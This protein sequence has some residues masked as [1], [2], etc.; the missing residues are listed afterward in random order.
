MLLPADNNNQ[1][2]KHVNNPIAFIDCA[3][4]KSEI[5]KVK[6]RVRLKAAII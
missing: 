2:G 5:E 3:W 4:V 1:M 6:K